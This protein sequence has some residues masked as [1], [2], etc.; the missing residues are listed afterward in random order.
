[1]K[2]KSRTVRTLLIFAGLG[3]VALATAFLCH[4]Y[5][6]RYSDDLV[7]EKTENL[8]TN[9]VGL[10]L[11][12]G[13]YTRKGYINPYFR[14]RVNAAAELWHA[15]KVRY[16]VVSGDNGRRSY[17]EATDMKKELIKLGV[18]A[19]RIY[20][21]YAGFRTLDSVVRCRKIFGQKKFTIISQRF[22]NERAV[23]LAKQKGIEAVAY[24]CK[25]VPV[26]FNYREYLAR[27][28]AVLDIITHKKPRFLG[29]QITIGKP[30]PDTNG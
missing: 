28:K 1:M 30:Q 19:N 10:V 2:V 5:I 15:G 12:T 16:L 20:M 18:P 7:F 9:E 27:V 3:I 4:R 11:G 21:D 6:S 25:D 26:R 29:P 22:H 17:D 24:N 8:P 13:K 14:Y 23:F